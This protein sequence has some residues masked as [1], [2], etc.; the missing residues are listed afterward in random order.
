MSRN[1]YKRTTQGKRR[2]LER[3]AQRRA[4]VN[5]HRPVPAQVVL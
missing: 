3:K 1:N 4:K 5:G 2:T